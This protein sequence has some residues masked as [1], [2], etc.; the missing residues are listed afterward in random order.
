MEQVDLREA[1][2]I[3]DRVLPY[4]GWDVVVGNCIPAGFESYGKIFHP[5]SQDGQPLTWK[6]VGRRYGIVFDNESNT[7]EFARAIKEKGDIDALDFPREGEMP[8][9]LLKTLLEILRPFTANGK[10]R[11]FQRGPHSI[12]RRT[13]S[14][15]LVEAD[16]EEVPAYFRN[17][18][19]GY[20][21]SVD[22]TWIIFTDIDQ[23]YTMVGGS[24]QLIQQLTESPLEVLPCDVRTR[25]SIPKS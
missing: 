24:A 5:F 14:D 22:R 2:W 15:D 4:D 13:G 7:H 12:Y 3:D 8:L 1:A 20:L 25:V 18:F 21:Y 23:D 11:I 17:Y 9:T 19:I 6:T 10:A 16:L